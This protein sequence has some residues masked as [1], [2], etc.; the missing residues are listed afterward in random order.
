M[1]KLLAGLLTG[2]VGVAHAQVTP[3]F[4]AGQVLTAQQLNSAFALAAT[5]ASPVFTGTVTIPSGAVLNTPASLVLTNATGLPVAALTGIVPVANGGTGLG[6]IA[7]YNTMVG[8]G[9][10]SVSLIGPGV[11][12]TLYASN[13]AAAY[14]SF[15]TKSAL[16]IAASGVNSDITSLSGLTTP[17]SVAQGG[18][19]ITSFGTGVATALGQNV[20]GSGSIVLSTSPTINQPNIQGVTNGSVAGA[21]QVGQPLTNSA[22][23]V[24]LSNAVSA[25]C[26]S[27]SLTAGDWNVWGNVYF[28]PAGSTMQSQLA[29][30]INTTS[31]TLPAIPN[32]SVLTL[33][34]PAGDVES[35]TAP[36][37]IINVSGS[38][39]V[40]L[41]ANASFSVSTETAS[42]YI[43]ARRVH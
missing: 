26:T 34:I 28:T 40:Y 37:Q 42:C 22:S 14:P 32:Y 1:K 11:T 24:S 20:T 29:V 2:L 5:V 30:G 38:T 7:Q 18:T 3:Q 36:Q 27:I 16:G 35:L 41:V 10:G 15:Q 12:G 13:G 43:N 33:S 21:G 4:Q 9:A 31:A 19:G 17:L 25:N 39:T 6:T 8:N 23:G